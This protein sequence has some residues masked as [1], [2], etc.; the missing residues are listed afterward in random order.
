MG[1]DPHVA[2]PRQA[3]LDA[4]RTWACVRG[5]TP[6]AP[7]HPFLTDHDAGDDNTACVPLDTLTDVARDLYYTAK[8]LEQMRKRIPK[9]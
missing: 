2:P 7:A 6:Q 3:P 4:P 8:V 5:P 9:V 1:H